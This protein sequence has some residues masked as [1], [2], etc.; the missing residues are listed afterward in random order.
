[1]KQNNYTELWGHSFL[2][3]YNKHAAQPPDPKSRFF[4][5]F[6]GFSIGSRLPFGDGR[7]DVRASQ[8][9]SKCTDHARRIPTMHHGHP[10]CIVDTP[11][12]S[13]T[14]PPKTKLLSSLIY[15]WHFR[16]FFLVTNTLFK[17]INQIF[18]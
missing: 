15:F 17:L 1:M 5:G 8:T 2:K 6:P 12:A 3:I 11:S 14:G 16:A 9:P 18:S 4:P 7:H 10:C 13:Q